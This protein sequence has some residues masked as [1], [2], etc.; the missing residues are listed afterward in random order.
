MESQNGSLGMTNKLNTDLKNIMAGEQMKDR[1]ENMIKMFSPEEQL[2]FEFN[3][4]FSNCVREQRKTLGWTQN[5][6]AEKS[7]VNRVTIA[8]IEMQQ[9]TVS[10]EVMLKLLQALGMTIQ[11]VNL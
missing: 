8:K 10:V 7:G 11:F 9:R 2:K 4:V 6:L 3:Y 5:E 1:I